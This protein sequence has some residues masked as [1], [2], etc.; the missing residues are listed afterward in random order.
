MIKFLSNIDLID[1]NIKAIDFLHK[2]LIFWRESEYQPG[3]TE[4]EAVIK[5]LTSFADTI[6]EFP[7]NLVGLMT[8]LVG[9]L[10]SIEGG[11]EEPTAMM[12]YLLDIDDISATEFDDEYLTWLIQFFSEASIELRMWIHGVIVAENQNLAIIREQSAPTP[13]I[14]SLEPLQRG[15]E[16]LSHTFGEM[17]TLADW[18]SGNLTVF[19]QDVNIFLMQDIPTLPNSPQQGDIDEWDG[20]IE[21]GG[22]FNLIDRGAT[23]Y[24]SEVDSVAPFIEADKY[25]SGDVMI[26]EYPDSLEYQGPLPSPNDDDDIYASNDIS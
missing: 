6:A 17:A 8:D 7:E 10:A 2:Y 5:A 25:F 26:E 1:N 4:P 21:E 12:R 13:Y 3:L 9:T 14:R 22:L 20:Y 11:W 23:R 15:L 24:N 16:E 19:R 18:A